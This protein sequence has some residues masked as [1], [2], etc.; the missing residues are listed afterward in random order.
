VCQAEGCTI[1][2]G[3]CEAHVRRE[4]LIDRV[5]VRDHHRRPVAAGR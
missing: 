3:W 4:A 2:A 1:P 5:E